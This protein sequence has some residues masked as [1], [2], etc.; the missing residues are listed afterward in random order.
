MSL[1]ARQE[2]FAQE[3]FSTGN[4]SE[5]YRRAYESSRRWKES[6]V[7]SKASVLSKNGKVQARY[8]ELVKASQER[9]ET[10]VDTIDK[11]L[12]AA[13]QVAKGDSKAAAMV[14][15]AMGLAKLHGLDVETQARVRE[16]S[17]PTN[18]TDVLHELARRLPD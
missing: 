8:E 15:A 9:N 4:K 10:S 11:M 13:W 7:N 5:A 3:W 1:T 18:M 16:F 2:K 6:T 14:S 17:G 12:K